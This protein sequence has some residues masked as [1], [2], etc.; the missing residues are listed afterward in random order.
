MK[1]YKIVQVKSR[2]GRPAKQKRTLDALGLTRMGRTVVIEASPQVE[3]M[4]NKVQH[5][6]SVEELNG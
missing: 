3:G 6:V 4:I 5:L 2:I 1:K